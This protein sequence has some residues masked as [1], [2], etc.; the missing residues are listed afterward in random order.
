MIKYGILFALAVLCGACA[1]HPTAPVATAPGNPYQPAGATSAPVPVAVPQVPAPQPVELAAGNEFRVR[2]DETLDTRRNRSGDRFT[3]TLVEPVGA[4]PEG[5]RFSGHL[6]EAKH[7]GHFKGRAV[8]GMTLDAFEMGG[9]EY[10]IDTSEAARV[11]GSHK[12]RNFALIGGGAGAGA[13]IGALAGGGAG[14]LI[15]AG[16]GAAAGTATAGFS[17]RKQV[18]VPVESAL[19]FRLRQNVSI[20]F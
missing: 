1:S 17:G 18:R 8:L 5:T 9:R 11:S 10:R 2:L 14:A 7:S 6:I 3:A 16:A 13:A 12:K 4:I 15:G 20:Q 19:T